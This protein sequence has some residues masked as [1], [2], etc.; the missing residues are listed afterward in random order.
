MT[1]IFTSLARIL[2]TSFAIVAAA[3][4]GLALW[5]HYMDAPWTRDGHIRAD[6]VAVAPDVSGLIKDV[7]V[8]DN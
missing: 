3:P 6:V 2:I 7:L 8:R 4:V 1:R 5:D